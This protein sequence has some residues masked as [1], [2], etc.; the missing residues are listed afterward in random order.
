M[1]MR[2]LAGRGTIIEAGSEI[3]EGVTIGDYCIIR[4]G[5]KIGANTKIA[6]FVELRADTTV[7][8]GCYLDSRVT[9]SGDCAIG[10]GV[11][12][13]YD[14][15]IA[16][17]CVIG[18]GS[19]LSPRV[20]TNNLDSAKNPIGGAKLGINVFVGTNA[21]LH[22]GVRIGD[23]AVIGALSFVNRDIPPGARVVGI[24]ARIIS[25]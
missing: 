15:I 13:R 20:M 4:S 6:N 8:A 23:G 9:T 2:H 18:N 14:T 7:G 1:S 17:G 19:Y 12:L 10:D 24:P 25:T 22:H 16:R 21:V 5:V 3:D 11:V